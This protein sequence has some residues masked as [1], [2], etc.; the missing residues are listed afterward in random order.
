M[1]Q[2]YFPSIFSF[3]GAIEEIGCYEFLK[4]SFVCDLILASSL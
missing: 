2:F 4:N 3:Y 1:V